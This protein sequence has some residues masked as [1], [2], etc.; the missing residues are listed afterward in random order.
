MSALRRWERREQQQ[1]QAA[2]PITPSSYA[3]PRANR[4]I[5]ELPRPVVANTVGLWGC[6][7]TSTSD[8]GRSELGA[9]EWKSGLPGKESGTSQQG[10][11]GGWTLG[12]GLVEWGDH[13]ELVVWCRNDAHL[14]AAPP[15]MLTSTWEAPPDPGP[16]KVGEVPDLSV[17]MK[18]AAADYWDTVK[19]N[20]LPTPEAVQAVCAA[21]D[22]LICECEGWEK[23]AAACRCVWVDRH[24]NH[25]HGV[26]KEPIVATVDPEILEYVQHVVKFGAPFRTP[27][28]G[29]QIKSKPYS[30][31]L[32]Y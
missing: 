31:Y 9:P 8:Q 22:R 14:S 10:K 20:P 30:S 4:R 13:Q 19:A 5:G 3:P 18:R 16:E 1:E 12:A 17:E 27:N 28:T 15:K 23:A 26:F 25:L 2:H 29:E 6:L 21:G 7:R 11:L 32:E 24:G